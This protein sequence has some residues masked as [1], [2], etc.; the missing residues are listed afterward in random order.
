M[1]KSKLYEQWETDS[2]AE[3]EGVWVRDMAPDFHVK[4]ARWN[5]PK[6]REVMRRLS[7]PY[8]QQI[9]RETIGEDLASELMVKAMATAIVMDWEGAVGKDGKP[10][11]YSY[12][13]V[14]TLLTDLPDFRGDVQIAARAQEQYRTESIAEAEKNSKGSSA[15]N[16]GGET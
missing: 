13:N 6:H 8:Q 4:V 11:H 16:S 5:N 9:E 12:D 10:L 15:G 14:V 3:T 1:A 7:K 2:D